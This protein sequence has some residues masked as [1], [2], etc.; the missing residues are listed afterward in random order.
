MFKNK[1]LS[2]LLIIFF[3]GCQDWI[4]VSP[5]TEVKGDEIFR[6][7]DGFKS[8]LIGIYGRMTKP[9]TYGKNLTFGFVEQLVQRYDNYTVGMVPSDEDRA[10]IYDFKNNNESKGSINTI[11]KEM[12]QTIANI[13]NLIDNLDKRGDD[14]ILTKGY[15]NI[16]EG[17]AYGLRAYHYFDL[18]RLWGPIYSEDADALSLPWRNELGYEKSPLISANEIVDNILSDLMHAE[19]MLAE[20][21]MNF[22]PDTEGSFLGYRKCRMNLMAVKALMARVY[23]YTGDK[24]NAAKYAKEVIDNSN[25]SLVIDN[26][27]DVSFSGETLFSLNMFNMEELLMS[28]WKNTVSM[29]T[30]FWISTDNIRTVYEFYSIGLNDIRYKNGYGFLHGNNQYMCRKYIGTHPEFKNFVP[31]IRLSEMYLILAESIE[32]EKSHTYINELR[33]ARGISRSNNVGTGISEAD[34]I[35]L[36][37]KE[38]QKEFFAEGQWFYFL[39]RHNIKTFYRCPVVEMRH[40]TLPIPDDEVEFGD[41]SK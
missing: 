4:D 16:I 12:Y 8:A 6:T 24:A 36:L 2:F 28:D 31:M 17:E 34:R 40:Y 13:N 29:N 14:V 23:L 32:L 15:R 35:E 26:S 38:Y 22:G 19:M 25:L 3:V 41:V 20:D 5:K 39:K 18:L 21:P 11:W 9:E 1:Y 7:E 10:K 27:R 33:N 30:E 37:N